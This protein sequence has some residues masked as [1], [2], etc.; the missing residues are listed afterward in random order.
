M[1]EIYHVSIEIR[2]SLKLDEPIEDPSPTDRSGQRNEAKMGKLQDLLKY[3]LKNV[4]SDEKGNS[5]CGCYRCVVCGEWCYFIGQLK[6]FKQNDTSANGKAAG[7]KKNNCGCQGYFKAKNQS[8][9]AEEVRCLKRDLVYVQECPFEL[10]GMGLWWWHRAMVEG[11]TD[12]SR[13]QAVREEMGI[14]LHSTYLQNTC[15]SRKLQG[16]ALNDTCCNI[17]NFEA[18]DFSRHIKKHWWF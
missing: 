12:F 7:Q 17:E 1:K 9:P 15:K 5:K 14:P 6:A 8:D 2:R 18:T 16:L 3:M 4:A 13:R 11:S 10:P